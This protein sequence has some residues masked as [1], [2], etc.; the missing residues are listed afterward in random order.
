MDRR[1]HERGG[2]SLPIDLAVFGNV[3]VLWGPVPRAAVRDKL[4]ELVFGQD[5]VERV[6]DKLRVNGRAPRQL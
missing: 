5:G 2:T 1:R 3:A 6:V 4:E